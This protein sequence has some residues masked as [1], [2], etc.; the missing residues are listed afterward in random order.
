[1]SLTTLP[2]I[3]NVAA[4]DRR[5]LL[6]D[7]INSGRGSLPSL[8]RN[9]GMPVT[10]RCVTPNKSGARNWDDVDLE[11]ARAA[12]GIRLVLGDADK[13]PLAGTWGL[14]Y[15]GS[16]TGLAALAFDIS[17]DDL[18]TALNAHAGITTDGGITTVTKTGNFYRITF[19]TVGAKD[20]FTLAANGL[21]PASSVRVSQ[22][23]AGDST[24]KEVW[25]FE[26]KQAPYAII[27][28]WT[29]GAGASVTVATVQAGSG[30]QNEVQSI[31]L[32]PGTYG[33]T[34]SL[35]LTLAVSG[36]PTAR[37]YVVSGT[38]TADELKA[39]LEAHPGCGSGKLTVTGSSALG[40]LVEFAQ[41]P[42]ALTDITQMVAANINLLAPKYVTGTLLLNRDGL[43]RA[44]Q[45]A[46]ADTIS[47]TLEVEITF[48]SEHP[49]TVFQENVIVSKDV[50]DLSTLLSAINPNFPT[51]SEIVRWLAGVTGYT[52]GGATN[53]D[54]I[55]SVALP[56]GLYVFRHSGGDLKAFRLEGG[57]DAESSPAVVRPDDYHG[58]TNARVWKLQSFGAGGGSG[59][60][61][62]LTA[63]TASGNTDVT[64]ASI[65][66]A[67][68]VAVNGS[69][70]F[71]RTFALLTSGRTAGDR[72]RLTAAISA[73]VNRTV[74]VRNA[75]SGGTLLASAASQAAASTWSA[76]LVFNGTAFVHLQSG[77]VV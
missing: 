43:Y 52:G 72:V 19:T 23:I 39:L 25:I 3:I 35:Q 34:Y 59:S 54:G 26:L 15:D 1:M 60:Y 41:S 57:T 63:V 69:G 55:D 51:A 9:D 77:F 74:E 24:T 56:L 67:A 10:L 6:T 32:A 76:D 64:P 58:T 66:H 8:I 11:A 28:N 33:G 20:D 4:E 42:V 53:L 50:F 68:T 38:A 36:T 47:P 73:G 40:Y 14:A 17:A 45:D 27:D 29:A 61:E 21:Q 7:F 18:K 71:T 12:G 2:L 22:L 65:N 31:T 62:A 48:P 75:T 49:A 5:G 13:P 44:F 30:S 16:S 70:T 37:T 46:G